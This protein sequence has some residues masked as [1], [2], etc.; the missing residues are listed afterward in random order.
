MRHTA[1]PVEAVDVVRASDAVAEA[2]GGV[3]VVEVGDEELEEVV[4]R[5]R[6]MDG[7]GGS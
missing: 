2:E 1:V 7:D 5:N 6:D 3:S 4:S